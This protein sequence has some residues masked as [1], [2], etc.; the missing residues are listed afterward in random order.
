M[1]Q[2]RESL[3]GG[4]VATELVTTLPTLP[5]YEIVTVHGIA[6]DISAARGKGAKAKGLDAFQEAMQ[7]V[8][9]SAALKGANAIVGLQVAH[10][11]GSIGGAGFGD[12]VGTTLMG[13][14]VTVRPTT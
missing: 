2:F 9:R 8:R 6:A 14:A 4:V 7:G 1:T 13:T 11:S 10:F 3:A 12:A 5:G